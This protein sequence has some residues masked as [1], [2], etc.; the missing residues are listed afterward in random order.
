[1]RCQQGCL[2]DLTLDSATVQALRLAAEAGSFTFE[3][4]GRRLITVPLSF[5]GF[6]QALD[7]SLKP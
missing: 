3:G 2:A 5:R 4:G 1:M 6:A 7:A